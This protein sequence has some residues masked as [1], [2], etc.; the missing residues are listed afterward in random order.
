MGAG[1]ST[2]RTIIFTIN[3]KLCEIYINLGEKHLC[4]I[5]AEHP[6]Y[7]EW[8][9]NCKEV[10]I[11]LCCEEAA[12]IILSETK[13]FSTSEV[14]IPYEDC[15]EYN[16]EIYSYLYSVREKILNY[17]NTANDLNSC[18]RNILWYCNIIQQNI[19]NNLLDDEN[20]FDIHS[21]KK[22]DIIKLLEFF[23]TLDANSDSWIAYLNSCI[24][25]YKKHSSKILEFEKQNTEI[26]NYLKNISN[27]FIWRYFL[28]GTFDEEIISKISLM[29][30]S[31]C[32]IK[33]LFFCKWIE[34][35]TIGLDD[36]I[37]LVRNYSEEIEY[38]EDNLNK[39]YDACY[40]LE[41]FSLENLISLF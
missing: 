39:L 16:T 2:R 35:G 19:D 7:Y 33:I 11:G 28:K 41:Y 29:A 5:C 18:I 36:C 21:E 8:F 32:I 6:R 9:K 38:N 10:G 3:K 40:E 24:N 4:Q 17:I 22:S 31:I 15:Y 20:I 37:D 30:I 25:I 1:L 34:N 14:N 12:R 26:N 23:L 13:P 27:Y